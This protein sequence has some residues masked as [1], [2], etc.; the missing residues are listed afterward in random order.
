MVEVE[1]TMQRSEAARSFLR[2]LLTLSSER[3]LSDEQNLLR[4]LHRSA[5]SDPMVTY[6]FSPPVPVKTEGPGLTHH[7]NNAVAAAN[8]LL[9]WTNRGPH[10]NLAVRV[11]VTVIADEMEP[12]EARKAF[13]AA[14][15]EE[16][17]LIRAG[18]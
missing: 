2:K 18:G 10:W 7:V 1:R 6:W 9:K 15:E 5:K 4:G 8:E 12:E 11:C 17:K 16:G 13:L 3:T 14:A